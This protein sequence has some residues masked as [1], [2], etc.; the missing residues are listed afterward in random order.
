MLS[1]IA[2]TITKNLGYICMNICLQELSKISQSGHTRFNSLIPH[3][4]LA[5]PLDL[6]APLY[7]DFKLEQN[8][9]IISA[10]N[11]GIH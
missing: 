4:F 2:Q 10:K 8:F 3:T 9:D 7:Q 6:C 11:F 1:K 5:R